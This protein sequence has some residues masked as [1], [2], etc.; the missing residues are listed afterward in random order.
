LQNNSLVGIILEELPSQ[1]IED[2]HR[3]SD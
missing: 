2:H 1:Y 3:D